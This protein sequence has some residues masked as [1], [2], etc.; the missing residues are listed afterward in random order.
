MEGKHLKRLADG[1]R[2]QWRLVEH[3]SNG[4]CSFCKGI[5]SGTRVWVLSGINF[6]PREEHGSCI[7]TDVKQQ[8]MWALLEYVT[9]W[10]HFVALAELF[11]Y[12]QHFILCTVLLLRVLECSIR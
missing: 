3:Y 10:L 9:V 5:K 2:C 6:V 11:P 4:K 12:G 8:P 7:V 1:A